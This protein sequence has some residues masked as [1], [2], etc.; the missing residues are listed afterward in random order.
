[1]IKSYQ[2]IEKFLKRI[3]QQASSEFLDGTLLVVSTS[4]VLDFSPLRVVH[5][6][7]LLLQLLRELR[8]VPAPD[9]VASISSAL[10]TLLHDLWRYTLQVVRLTDLFKNKILGHLLTLQ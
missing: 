7:E 9:V 10:G 4:S 5:G 3:I 6:S 8:I 2:K 1:M